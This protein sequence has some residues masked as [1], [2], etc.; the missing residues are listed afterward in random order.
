MNKFAVSLPVVILKE[1]KKFVAHTPVLDISTSA[2][3]F[4]LVQK[5]FAEVVQIFLEELQEK[6]TIDEVLSDLG[7]H[8][9]K[10]QWSP[11]VLVKHD[12]ESILIPIAL[13]KN[14]SSYFH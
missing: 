7:W 2:D 5:R 12:M 9:V 8:K 6:G 10:K 11:P 1:G 13:S 14:A 4:K 3:S